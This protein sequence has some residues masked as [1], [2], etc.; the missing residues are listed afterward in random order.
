[1]TRPLLSP[2]GILVAPTSLL[3]PINEG[4]YV[5]TLRLDAEAAARMPV[6]DGYEPSWS[7]D[8]SN[9]EFA[10]KTHGFEWFSQ[11]RRLREPP[12]VFDVRARLCK[13][14]THDLVSGSV[15]RVSFQP[16]G[17]ALID[18]AAYFGFVPCNAL[19]LSAVQVCG[20]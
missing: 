13:N 9:A 16:R 11:Q 8:R 17:F 10:F 15:V 3:E 19:H 7:E 18:S 2:R 1:M 20:V 12:S 4:V 14:L 5:L 6:I